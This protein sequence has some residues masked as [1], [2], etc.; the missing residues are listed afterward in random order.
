MDETIMNSRN[1]GRA[2]RRCAT[3]KTKCVYP[4]TYTSPIG[5]CERC[6]RLKKECVIRPVVPHKRKPPKTFVTPT[7]VT[8]QISTNLW[9]HSRR[10]AQLE[11]KLDGIV[12]LLTSSQASRGTSSPGETISLCSNPLPSNSFHPVT[13]QLSDNGSLPD[14]DVDPEYEEVLFNLYQ[15]NM[16]GYFPFVVIP[17]DTTAKNLKSQKP[18]LLKAIIM[19]ASYQDPAKQTALGKGIMEYL[20]ALLVDLRLNKPPGG[21]ER[22]KMMIETMRA[23]YGDATA[24]EP[25]TLEERRALL[26]CFYLTSMV[27]ATIRKLDA[28]RF[29]SYMD[30]GCRTLLEAG[31]YPSDTYLTHL[32]N[33]Q[34]TVERISE[35]P[36]HSEADSSSNRKPPVGMYV[37]GVQEEMTRFKD[38]LPPELQQSRE[39]LPK[40]TLEECLLIVVLALVLLYYYSAQIRLYEVGVYDSPKHIYYG[41]YPF[42]HLE[43]LY[44]C[45]M[46]VK[47][48]LDTYY[49]IP[50]A[51]YF[52]FPFYTW[53]QLGHA[54][55]VLS[56]LSLFQ[57]DG[58]DLRHIKTIVDFSE[59]IDRVATQ[60]EEARE[61]YRVNE[62]SGESEDILSKFSR[63]LRRVKGWFEAKLATELGPEIPPQPQS[64]VTPPATEEL[65]DESLFEQL[66]SSFWDEIMGSWPFIP[67]IQ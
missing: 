66:D 30:E 36:L 26:G 19:V 8:S 23:A 60:F 52:G 31:E 64:L 38:S 22:Y 34:K 17:P 32:V 65:I 20:I 58:W 61:F 45:I 47:D 39:Y 44:S 50:P 14:P 59:A 2:C 35:S 49:S 40:P 67:P 54:L 63:K 33:L 21:I 16:A 48:L 51:S 56:R 9:N 24:S 13:P 6:R 4:N 28:L 42:G 43:I 10:V 25:H 12:N 27:S 37:K 41:N 29:T 11:Q 55:I 53:L 7:P 46:A 5:Q 18:F 62:L 15:A 1:G 57:C 3:A